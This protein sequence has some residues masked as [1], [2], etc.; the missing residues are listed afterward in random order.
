MVAEPMVAGL[1]SA[2]FL[3]TFL[4]GGYVLRIY[5]QVREQ[6]RELEERLDTFKYLEE[7]L[8][9]MSEGRVEALFGGGGT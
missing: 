1:A 7:Q 4:F 5:L 8:D 6:L 9:S 2:Y 3:A